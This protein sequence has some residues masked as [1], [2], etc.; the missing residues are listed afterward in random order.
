MHRQGADLGAA[1]EAVDIAGPVP[2]LLGEICPIGDRLPSSATAEEKRLR[3]PRGLTKIEISPP[4]PAIGS[5]IVNWA[6]PAA[7]FAATISP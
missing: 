4:Q 2:K 3:R 7:W 5:R 6:P 1:Q